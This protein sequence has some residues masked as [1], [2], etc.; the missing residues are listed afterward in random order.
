MNLCDKC[1]ESTEL[2]G[3]CK[4]KLDSGLLSETEIIVLRKIRTLSNEI[5]EFKQI[6]VKNV[7]DVGKIIIF[8]DY[9]DLKTMIGPNSRNVRKLADEVGKFVRITPLPNSPKGFIKHLIGEVPV[10]RIDKI[11]TEDDVLFRIIIKNFYR[12]RIKLS[13]QEF[14]EKMQKLIEKPVELVFE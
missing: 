14:E 1:L 13:K 10:Y 2:C 8:V 5:P 12:D 3:E 4:E 9:P 6:D 7:V 11:Y